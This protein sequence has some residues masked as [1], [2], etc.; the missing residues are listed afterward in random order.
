MNKKSKQ[1]KK[2]K[3]VALSLPLHQGATLFKPQVTKR[4]KRPKISPRSTAIAPTK[5]VTMLRILLSQKTRDNL[6][7]L[8]VS[9]C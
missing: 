2:L 5:K 1:E 9:D 3:R 8:H 6:G 7:K 4:K